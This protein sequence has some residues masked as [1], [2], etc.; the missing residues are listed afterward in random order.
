MRDVKIFWDSMNIIKWFNGSQRCLNYILS[1]LLDEVIHIKS[2]FNQI[3]ACHI[4]REH[5]SDADLL[6]K[7]GIRQDMGHWVA[8]EVDG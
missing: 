5:N 4:Y 1:P 6:S 3:T 7:E 2:F 8:F